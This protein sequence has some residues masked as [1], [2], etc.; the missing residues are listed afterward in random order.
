MTQTAKMPSWLNVSAERVVVQLSKA[1]EANGMQVDSLSLRAPTV[2]DIRTAQSAA[3]G[4]DEQR[5]LNLFASL[6]EVGVKD[7]EGLSLKDYGRLQAGY[8]RLVQDDEL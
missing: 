5:E 8:F 7:L 1:S 3:S 4:D 2:R 6:A